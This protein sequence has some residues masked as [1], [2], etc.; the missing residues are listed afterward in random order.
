MKTRD[1]VFSIVLIVYL[2]WVCYYRL[3]GDHENSIHSMIYFSMESISWIALLFRMIYIEKHPIIM[4]SAK[5]LL[6]VVFIFKIF[7]GIFRAVSFTAF[8]YRHFVTNEN[9][10]YSVVGVLLILSLLI[11]FVIQE[12]RK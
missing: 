9:V 1:R 12:F 3:F 6:W 2:L 7:Q 5:H 4:V 11:I 8:G 10:I